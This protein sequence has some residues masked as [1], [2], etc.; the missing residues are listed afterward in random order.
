MSPS[1]RIL[2]LAQSLMLLAAVACTEGRGTA[3]LGDHAVAWVSEGPELSHTLRLQTDALGHLTPA[4]AAD[5]R[6]FDRVG[7]R[8]DSTT[9]PDVDVRVSDDGGRSFGPWLPA[10][11]TW[12]EAIAHNAHADVPAGATHAQARFSGIEPDALGFVA[13]EL[14]VFEPDPLLDPRLPE[15]GLGVIHQELA[16]HTGVDVTRSEWGARDTRCSSTHSPYRITIHHTV[17]PNNDSM[18]MPQRMRQMQNFHMDTRGWCD[19]G[20]HFTVGQ[21]G[22]VYQARMENLVGAHVGGANTGNA[23]I[24]FI[25][26]FTDV[27]PSNQMFDAGAKILRAVSDYYGIAL[28][29]D[30]V[31]GHREYS[32]TQCPGNALYPKLGDLITLAQSYEGGTAKGELRGAIYH[33][34][35]LQDLS[36][37]I[38]GATVSLNTGASTTTDAQGWYVFDLEAGTYEITASAAGYGAES[39]SRSV[40]GGATSWGSIRLYPEAEAGSGTVRGVVFWVDDDSEFSTYV[41]DHSRRI[42]GATVTFD[43]G[44]HTGTTG[45]DGYYE[46][47]VPAGTYT[48]RANA[49]GYLEGTRP[50]DVTVTDGTLSWGSTHVLRPAEGEDA[51]PVVTL[52]EPPEGTTVGLSR[53]TVRGTVTHSASLASFT[54]NDEP[55]DV[56]DG[57]FTSTVHLS[58]GENVIEAVAEDVL[59]QVGE[60]VVTVFYDPDHSGIEGYVYDVIEGDAVRIPGATLTLADAGAETVTDA[61]GAFSLDLPPGSFGLSVSAEGYLT[62]RGALT[63]VEGRRLGLRIGL[64]PGSDLE[65]D[66]VEITFPTDG[67]MVDRRDVIVSGAVAVVDLGRVTVN[68]TEASVSAEDATFAAPI[69]LRAG[70]NEIEAIAWREDGT[71]VGR[72]RITVVYERS[73]CG[74]ATTGT[75]TGGALWLAPLLLGTW[76][77]GRRRPRRTRRA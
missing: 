74:C 44:G 39:L 73:G 1:R 38:A 48:V 26:T 69:R 8:F 71:E 3:G 15:T 22:L 18:T 40:S 43:P 32:S 51:A 14:F 4:I 68:G 35:D 54:V 47:A 64:E 41:G 49:D 34:D 10:T 67:E 11:V 24:S 72:A 25:G 75:G 30:R 55:V 7:I 57:A 31:R 76:L 21:D 28:N 2:R 19:I 59:G 13:V 45:S 9:T 66:L 16:A 52:T 36:R 23:G 20:Y 46:I 58:P 6:P 53:L 62:H 65:E 17:T 42:S 63:I 70:E 33:G 12:R 50:D 60:D 61:A 56:S 37:R 77:A 5:G 29:R 27:L